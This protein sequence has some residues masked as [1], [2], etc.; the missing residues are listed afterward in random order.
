MWESKLVPLRGEPAFSPVA[1]DGPLS[2]GK[3]AAACQGPDQ[4]MAVRMQLGTAEAVARRAGTGRLC[5][6]TGP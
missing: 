5:E 6:E 3:D 2:R 1:L 4:S